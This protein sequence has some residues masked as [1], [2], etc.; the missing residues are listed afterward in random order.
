MYTLHECF[1]CHLTNQCLVA[2]TSS[3][4]ANCHQPNIERRLCHWC[5]EYGHCVVRQRK[6]TKWTL[7]AHY[8]SAFRQQQQFLGNNICD[9]T[10]TLV[11][12]S[13]LLNFDSPTTSKKMDGKID[14][15]DDI[16]DRKKRKHV[17]V[18]TSPKHYDSHGSGSLCGFISP[19]AGIVNAAPCISMDQ[20]HLRDYSRL[21]NGN[22]NC[23]SQ[24]AVLLESAKQHR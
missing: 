4:S 2:K 19:F 21:L 17:R 24:A 15:Q 20:L 14:W 1:I 10:M 7:L 8:R 6:W 3:R 22:K 12:T 13:T 16:C 9:E 11:N 23:N 18:E 5:R